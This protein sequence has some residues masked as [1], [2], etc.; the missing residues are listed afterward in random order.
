MPTVLLIRH[1]R[2]T[3]NTSGVLA[4]RSPG[5]ALDD[6]GRTQA[7]ALAVRLGDLKLAAIVSSPLQRCL[8]TV[9]PLAAARGLDVRTE[10]GLVECD[11]GDWTGRSLGSLMKERLWR[12]VQAHPSGAT[13]PGGESMSAMAARAGAAVRDW[14]RRIAE[15]DGP[16]AVWAACSHGDLIKA[17]V[18][19][20]LGLHL[21][22]FQ[23]IVVDP[24]SVTAIRWTEL[25]PFLVKLNDT[26]GE[27]D[28]Y[29]PGKGKGRRRRS[30]EAAVGGGAGPAGGH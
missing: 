9:A 3:A 23:R 28:S 29:R 12:T 20:A 13:F 26:G 22:L 30:S 24:G 11:Y 25:R 16:A 21:D 14:D 6:K 17:I 2:S 18:A 8:E 10:D 1:G 27:V 7:Q 15:E 5:I 4:G 19:E